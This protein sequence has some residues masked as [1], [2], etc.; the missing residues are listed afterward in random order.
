MHTRS[1]AI[2]LLILYHFAFS[3]E[4]IRLNSLGFLP[5]S[6]KKATITAE[7]SRFEVKNLQGRTVLRGNVSG[8]HQQHDVNQ[9][10][11]IAD[12]SKLKKP[13]N[14][15]LEIADDRSAPFTVAENVYDFAFVTAMRAMYLWRCGTAVEGEHN[16]QIY[17]HAACHLNDGYEDRLGRP[18]VIRDGTGG[19]HDVGDHGKYVVNA[20]I[21]V[22]TMFLAWDHF[23]Q[24][25]EK[26]P[27]HL[28]ETA[29]GYPE[30][31]KELKWEIDWLLKMPYPDGSGRV[32]HKLTRTNFAGFIMPEDDDGKRFFTVWSSAATADF[33]AMTAMAARYFKPYDAVYAQACLD[34]ALK[35]YEYLKNN[36]QDE[37]FRQGDF[38]TGAYGTHDADDRIW[39]A[40]ELWETTGDPVYLADFE[41]RVR[42]NKP[43][44]RRGEAAPS[45]VR[46]IDDDWDWGNVRNLGAFT[47]LLSKRSD[48]DPE[49]LQKLKNDLPASADA[50]VDQAQKDVYGRP[51]ARY[52]WGCNGTVARQTLN[53]QIA[54]RFS[55]RKEYR[56]ACLD[57]I[58][59][60]FGR[61]VYG[62]SFVTGLGIDPPMHPHD[63]R[64]GA[65]GI[66]APWPGYIVGGGHSATGWVDEEASYA[67]NE[68]AINWQAALIYAL[69][70]FI[71]H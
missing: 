31:L 70:G 29:P 43:Q 51:S 63:R 37:P 68:V 12:F 24:Q 11:W 65:D 52:Y 5:P 32:S 53:L 16:G 1:A 48:K 13:G 67:T 60:L 6:P 19:W 10:V 36:P 56:N 66:E 14:Y 42:D 33:V 25:I 55:P 41:R 45:D 35:S 9:T 57:A 64:S 15:Y 44:T 4:T 59:H 22:G 50:I 2:I 47:Y 30:F 62:R 28:P 23:Q 38:R 46:L 71:S 69:A 34:A 21:T 26:H 54:Y 39:A 40:A 20:G 61:N 17:S 7:C 3:G 27:L 58:A 49:L 18:D 8:P